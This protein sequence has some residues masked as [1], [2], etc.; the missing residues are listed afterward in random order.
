M[1][2][3]AFTGI[4]LKIYEFNIVLILKILLNFGFNEK[5]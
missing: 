4:K 1:L 2:N 5:P 3:P